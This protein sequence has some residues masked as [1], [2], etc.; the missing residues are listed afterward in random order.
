MTNIQIQE[1]FELE[2]NMLDNDLEKP[3]S[4]DTEY[5]VNSGILKFIKTRFTGNNYR[6]KG[7]E[8]DQKRIDD[9]RT[10][11]KQ[12]NLPIKSNSD[13]EFVY[14]LPT[15]YL[16]LLGDR[17]GILPNGV[18]DNCWQK[19]EE[20]EYIVR[21]TDTLEATIETIDRQLENSL[22]EHNL[23]YCQARPLKLIIGNNIKLYTDRK[24]IVSKYQITYLKKPDTFELSDPFVEYTSLTD[25][26]IRECVKLAAQMYIENKGTNRYETYSN[27]VI[28][29]E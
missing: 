10:L 29:M 13:Y 6:V 3:A 16:Y 2:I 25:E 26:A 4:T 12:V 7:V 14:E 20:G 11:V 1:A 19:D 9:L 21:Y 5:W 24:Y 17:A 15:D 22:S 28:G 18:N 23:H 8:Q 27:E